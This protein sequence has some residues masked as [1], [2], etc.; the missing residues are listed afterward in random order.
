M[1]RQTDD[2]TVADL[3]GVPETVL[4]ADV[5]AALPAATPAPPWLCRV[6]A[7][8]WW[9]RASPAA[10]TALPEPL[11]ERAGL[12]LTVGAFLRYLD[13]PVGAY[14]EVLAV[15]HLLGPLPRLHIPFIAV[16]SLPSVQGGRTHWDLPKVLGSFARSDTAVRAEGTGW[17]ARAAAAPVGPALPVLGR[18]GDVQVDGAGLVRRSTSTMRGWGRL[19]RVDVDVDPACSLAG[20]LLPGRHRGAVLHGRVLVGPAR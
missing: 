1:A 10:R 14:E 19:A 6:E 20:W 18:V 11:R 8:L 5:L 13:T 3:P 15:P 2:V 7:V 9:H 16:D 17:W 4:D 12:P